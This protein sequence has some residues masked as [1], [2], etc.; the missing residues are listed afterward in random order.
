LKG[1]LLPLHLLI[2]AVQMLGP[3]SNGARDMDLLQLAGNDLLHT[4]EIACPR[5][6]LTSK[7]CL[8]VVIRPCV[9]IAERE[10]FEFRVYPRDAQAM[11]QGGI[12]IERLLRDS[13]LL[14]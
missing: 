13:T 3:A 14:R 7:L 11:R 4:C 5:L 10:V 12:D 1:E 9:D 8:D 6:L 2:D